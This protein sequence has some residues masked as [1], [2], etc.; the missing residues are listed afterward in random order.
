MRYTTTQASEC[1]S[2][3]SVDLVSIANKP[4]PASSLK[5]TPIPDSKHKING[6]GESQNSWEMPAFFHFTIIFCN[7]CLCVCDYFSI[8][9]VF[10]TFPS[11][12]LSLLLPF[13]LLQSNY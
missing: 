2:Y 3:D 7:S 1:W 9:T 4:D 6:K 5:Y 13:T 12:P 10:G 11:S 8:W